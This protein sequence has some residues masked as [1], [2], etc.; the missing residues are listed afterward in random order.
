MNKTDVKEMAAS[1]ND[2][3]KYGRCGKSQSTLTTSPRP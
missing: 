3:Q 1:L 2:H